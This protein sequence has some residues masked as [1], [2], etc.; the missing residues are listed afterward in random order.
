[1]GDR[2]G[3]NSWGVRGVLHPPPPNLQKSRFLWAKYRYQYISVG[4]I[5]KFSLV[6]TFIATC[7][8]SLVFEF[9]VF[10]P[11]PLANFCPVGKTKQKQGKQ[12]QHIYISVFRPLISALSR[13]RRAHVFSASRCGS[14]VSSIDR[15]QKY[16]QKFSD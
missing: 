2:Q 6:R 9:M 13:A 4:Q 5:W 16:R 15:Q 14:R 1:M 10:S 11:H 3:Q 8:P 7:C 12:Q